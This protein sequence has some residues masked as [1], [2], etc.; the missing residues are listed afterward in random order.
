MPSKSYANKVLMIQLR[1]VNYG[2][3]LSGYLTD[4]QLVFYVESCELGKLLQ[5]HIIGPDLPLKRAVRYVYNYNNNKLQKVT[6]TKSR[7]WEV[8][9][10]LLCEEY[11]DHVLTSCTLD[12]FSEKVRAMYERPPIELSPC[13]YHHARAIPVTENTTIGGQY[14]P[15]VPYTVE[16]ED[17]SDDDDDTYSPSM[18]NTTNNSTICFC[19][20]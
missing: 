17:E 6:A 1:N 9:L 14:R 20:M 16:S 4:K 10:N 11:T 13:P 8:A 2:P 5:F 12:K 7:L 18:L 15:L 19:K 3:D